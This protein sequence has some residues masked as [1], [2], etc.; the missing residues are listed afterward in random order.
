MEFKKI[1]YSEQDLERYY[2]DALL[3]EKKKEMALH[4][5]N[6]SACTSYL[7]ELKNLSHAI[8]ETFAI[9]PG[10]DFSQSVMQRIH[11]ENREK[12]E[13]AGSVPEEKK[14]VFPKVL[15]LFT[16]GRHVA[17]MAAIFLAV[18]VVVFFRFG[19]YSPSGRSGHCLVDYVHVPEGNAF[20]YDAQDNIKVVWVFEGD[21]QDE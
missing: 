10:K 21:Y 13:R 14:G 11:Q 5:Q 1:H 12:V 9:V 8:R 17:A 20:V 3:P 4:L 15:S 18:F 19:F 6:C 2:D 16:A 7:D